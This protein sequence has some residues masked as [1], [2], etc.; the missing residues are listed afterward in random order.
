MITHDPDITRLLN[1]L[2][3]RGFVERT[4]ALHDRRGI[5]SKI[6]ASGLKLLR[7][8]DGPIEKHSGETLHH[9]GQRKRRQLIKVLELVRGRG[10]AHGEEAESRPSK[11]SSQ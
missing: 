4:R 3:H 10:V 11:N 7:G 8:M 2:E 5:Y 1:R 6:T 9:V